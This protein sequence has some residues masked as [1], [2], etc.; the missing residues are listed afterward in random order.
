MFKTFITLFLALF[1]LQVNAQHTLILSEQE[2][3]K[4]VDEILADR[5][6]NLLPQL[7]QTTRRKR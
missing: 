2:R 7:M 1:F 4:V 6:D 5:L 3:A